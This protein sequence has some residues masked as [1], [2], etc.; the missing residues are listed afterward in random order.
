MSYD[1][2]LLTKRTVYKNA[3][4]N[5]YAKFQLGASSD[6][7]TAYTNMLNDNTTYDVTGDSDAT[8][9]VTIRTLIPPATGNYGGGNSGS[10]TKFFG[11][12]LNASEREVLA[13]EAWLEANPTDAGRLGLSTT[14]SN[15]SALNRKPLGVGGN[16][17][18]SG[19]TERRKWQ[20]TA[21]HTFAGGILVGKDDKIVAALGTN[22]L[23]GGPDGIE[24]YGTDTLNFFDG[25]AGS[26]GTAQPGTTVFAGD[27]VVSGSIQGDA[28][29]VIIDD[30]IQLEQGVTGPA[31]IG[32][33]P[34]GKIHLRHRGEG[35]LDLIEEDE[36]RQL[37]DK[38]FFTGQNTSSSRY[39]TSLIPNSN[40]AYLES[41]S[42]NFDD[43][44]IANIATFGQATSQL[45]IDGGSILGIAQLNYDPFLG[46]IIFQAVPIS[47][48]RYSIRIR[49]KK[50]GSSEDL[51]S[52]GT[53]EGLFLEM[54]ETDAEDINSSSQNRFY[55]KTNAGGTLSTAVTT[56]DDS[57]KFDEIFGDTQAAAL[58][59]AATI[60]VARPANS[61]VLDDGGGTTDGASIPSDFEV[62]TFTYTRTNANVKNASLVLFAKN[63][64]PSNSTIFI[65]YV[66]MTEAPPTNQEIQDLSQEAAADILA[67]SDS[68]ITD[69]QM[70]SVSNW[71]ALNAAISDT[72]DGNTNGDNAILV[73]TNGSL[74]AS[75]PSFN[76]NGILSRRAS[77][78]ADEYIVGVRL[79]AIDDGLTTNSPVSLFV[80]EDN[81]RGSNPFATDQGAIV[82]QP[83]T[84]ALSN[85][86]EKSI[87]SVVVDNNGV[88]KT[89][90]SA[91][92]TVTS[93]QVVNSPA[94]GGG[95]TTLTI[96]TE[97]DIDPDG[98][99]D[100]D[101][102][103]N[104]SN[105][106]Q[107][108]YVNLIGTYKPTVRKYN[109]SN[110]I[111]EING[112]QSAG[113][114]ATSFP[115]G[116]SKTPG[117]SSDVTEVSKTKAFCIGVKFNT[118]QKFLIDYFYVKPQSTSLDIA[119]TLADQAFV[120]AEGFVT[121][122]NELLI[123]ESGSL[124][125]NA[126]MAMLGSDG[127]P[128]GYY[129]YTGTTIL[130]EE[131]G[132]DRQVRAQATSGQRRI[133]TPPFLLGEADKF[134]IGL[135]LKTYGSGT[136]KISARVVFIQGPNDLPVGKS[137]LAYAASGF[138][139]DVYMP[140]NTADTDG[141]IGKVDIIA[142][143][144]ITT[145][146]SSLLV[147]FDRTNISADNTVT[148][149]AARLSNA[150]VA[151]IE[152][153]SSAASSGHADFALD[154]VLVKEQ[155][156]SFDLADASAQLR[157][158]EA[159]AQIGQRL[160]SVNNAMNQETGS[161]LAN[162]TFA[163]YD[164]NGTITPGI[165]DNGDGL[166]IPKNWALTRT[167]KSDGSSFYRAVSTTDTTQGP[168]GE[169]IH[170]PG[171]VLRASDGFLGGGAIVRHHQTN[172]IGL[173]SSYYTLPIGGSTSEVSA[174]GQTVEPT[175]RYLV[176]MQL[177][178]LTTYAGSQYS[179]L[180]IL[181]HETYDAPVDS[182]GNNVA[183]ALCTSSSEAAYASG[184]T[185]ASSFATGTG[186]GATAVK[187]FTE[188][189]SAT[190][191]ETKKI[192]LINLSD[193]SDTIVGYDAGGTPSDTSDDDVFIERWGDSNWHTIGGTYTPSTGMR[194]VCFEFIFETD[195]SN[196]V[197]AIDYVTLTPQSID[198]DFADTVAQARTEGAIDNLQDEPQIPGNLIANPY[199]SSAN[200]TST[201]DTFPKQWMPTGP[202]YVGG[203]NTEYNTSIMSFHDTTNKLGLKI[204]GGRG[205]VISKAFRTT[206]EDYEI[207][208][209]LQ[210]N[211]SGDY[212]AKFQVS[213]FEYDDDLLGGQEY[214]RGSQYNTLNGY[215]SLGPYRSRVKRLG[216]ITCTGETHG[217]LFIADGESTPS[218]QTQRE[219]HS[220]YQ[221]G[222]LAQSPKTFT[223]EYLP[224]VSVSGG[225]RSI[226]P[227]YA[228]I[229]IHPYD[230][231][232]TGGGYTLHHVTCTID[233]NATG[234]RLL[235]DYQ[236]NSGPEMMQNTSGVRS[237]S[238]FTFDY[239]K[240]SSSGWYVTLANQVITNLGVTGLFNIL[241]SNP[242]SPQSPVLDLTNQTQIGP[243]HSLRVLRR[244]YNNTSSVVSTA[245]Y[246]CFGSGTGHSSND[247]VTMTDTQ[248]ATNFDA[249][250]AGN[251]R[252]RGLVYAGVSH[253]YQVS[254]SNT[255]LQGVSFYSPKVTPYIGIDS[256]GK[257]LWFK[258]PSD[259]AAKLRFYDDNSRRNWAVMYYDG[260]SDALDRLYFEHRTDG[261]GGSATV[262]VYLD[263]TTNAGGSSGY[264]NAL[265]R[266]SFTGQHRSIPADDSLEDKVGMICVSTGEFDTRFVDDS[267]KQVKIN[268]AHPIV[269]LSTKR[270]QKSVFGVISS[271]EKIYKNHN[272]DNVLDYQDGAIGTVLTMADD[273]Q[274][275]I[276][277][278]SIGEGGIWVCNINGDLENG[279]YITSCE[280]PGYGMLQDDDLLHNYTVA[281]ITQDCNFELDNSKYDCV[282]FE[283]EGQT[284]RKAFVGC[285]YHCG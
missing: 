285:T 192:Q 172:T 83:G 121:A 235:G 241:G 222:N 270:N 198:A 124:V 96:N 99:V 81:T 269:D 127:L 224:T 105:D 134:S 130:L 272:D 150:R 60:T 234:N 34:D 65:D 253:K 273:D 49:Y 120:D 146:F 21:Q 94:I 201:T 144:P 212:E 122:T 40:F 153:Y 179:G 279:D 178:T 115:D 3:V 87:S 265:I 193:S 163:A 61:F 149:T 38:R 274:E 69:S 220:T 171:E 186:W 111:E 256:T 64:D 53:S 219:N 170:V 36:R 176:A 194:Y 123:Q 140:G 157:R 277:V 215:E 19:T 251:N 137:T 261:S 182:S 18:H 92:H 138:P 175:G 8:N 281:K 89:L 39:G 189:N 185:V 155:T 131:Q 226:T 164:Y 57:D 232:F 266:V 271:K 210:T 16:V 67:E 106:Y 132:G 95:N 145:S 90:G 97:I 35:F 184:T 15:D 13:F 239:R 225:T 20:G 240:A 199:F 204:A 98:T 229:W 25:V 169:D 88:I 249:Q 44:Q 188:G 143:Q 12:S 181:A 133:V 245:Y 158:D 23:E 242:T 42:N 147:T 213:V 217:V 262:G 211:N 267:E 246:R 79:K 135:R 6:E 11:S 244:D 80:V 180:R 237:H 264:T 102:D 260:S 151:A 258:H 91:S 30:V 28:G 209:R 177:K 250:F 154:Y 214:I 152:I 101:E 206:A 236:G 113:L 59:P 41:I 27:V 73:H 231:V 136:R 196:A 284:Y 275:R 33:T 223:I 26:K 168:S 228:S 129:P 74:D 108:Y 187:T 126:S 5:A 205:G 104:A 68:D 165:A 85:I 109:G 2:W 17:T 230:T 82:T 7:K 173:L 14:F 259:A 76:R 257:E 263:G 32:V 156:C 197:Y 112:E 70:A 190:T 72:L 46:G 160:D 29:V 93:T 48:E 183:F 58:S 22:G 4:T 100:E 116:T 118:N 52:D 283:F 191:S 1:A 207:K 208:I 248:T 51:T 119:S 84:A 114:T 31:G 45:R 200:L 24:G 103:G 166:Q 233:P 159:I 141:Q 238:D 268:D 66:V 203:S 54:H 50:S 255:D 37:E 161:L 254:S 243:G 162:S 55:I 110:V 71:T 75:A 63:L 56:S 227:K 78:D 278:N 9:D 282:E 86:Y 280:I 47:S 148:Q 276:L 125:S 195:D 107:N 252:F 128:A 174:G 117:T 43:E 10:E 218:T 247:E 139:T 167:A 216:E 62:K 142:N 77:C 202:N 221:A